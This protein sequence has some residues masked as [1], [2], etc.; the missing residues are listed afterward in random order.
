MRLCA[1]SVISLCFPKLNPIS[2]SG[3]FLGRLVGVAFYFA[4]VLGRKN[5]R[6]SRLHSRLPRCTTNGRATTLT[7]C[8]HA[9]CRIASVRTSP[10]PAVPVYVKA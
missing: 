10:T 8:S 1:C 3:E 6:H 4:S 7:L 9:L 2:V 5:V